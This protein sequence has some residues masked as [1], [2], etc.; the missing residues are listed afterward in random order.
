MAF[1]FE[2]PIS[3]NAMTTLT[4][5][6]KCP[7][8]G[9]W[10]GW[11]QRPDDKCEH[12]QAILDPQGLKAQQESEAEALRQKGKI[13]LSLIEIFP[14]DPPFTKFYKRIIQGFQLTFFAILSFIIWLV[15]ILA[16]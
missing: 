11:H 4:S 5:S 14:S 2:L 15:T 13:N 8:C 10:S 9:Q 12:C 1:T 7:S 6:R 16:G 3:Y